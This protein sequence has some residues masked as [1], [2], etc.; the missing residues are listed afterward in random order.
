LAVASDHHIPDV[1]AFAAGVAAALPA[2]QAGAIVTFGVKPRYPATGFG[3]IRPGAVLAPGSAVRHVDAFIEKPP[4]AR[5]ESLI[6]QGCLWN[7]G[8]FMFRIDALLAEARLHA[9]EVVAAVEAASPVEEA[10]GQLR[11][12]PT[13][14]QTPKIAFDVAVME[15]TSRAA[16]LPIDYEWSDLGSWDAIWAASAHDGAGN[17]VVGSASLTDGRNCLIRA[18]GGA[19]VIGLGLDGVAVVAEGHNVLVTSLELAAQLKPCL[20]S[21][22]QQGTLLFGAAGSRPRLDAIA[23]THLDWLFAKALPVWWCFG[24]DHVAGGF[25]ERLRWD[26]SPTGHARRA[27]VQARQIYVFATAAQL[28]WRGPW[29]AAMEHGLAYLAARFL[30]PD[31]LYMASVAADGAAVDRQALL[32]DQA[33]V[34]LALASVAAAA[35]EKADEQHATA[36]ALASQVERAFAH[37]GGGWRA[38]ETGGDLLADP[39]M[40]LFEASLAW[41]SLDRH[42]PWASLGGTLARHGLERM[43]DRRGDRI[44]EAFDEAWR[45]APGAKGLTLEPGHQFEWAWLLHRWGEMAGDRAAQKTATALFETGRRGID[46]QSGLVADETGDDLV[47][48]RRTYRLWPQTE[49]LKAA[50][51]LETDPARRAQESAA[52]AD[53]LASYY[54]TEPPGLWRD[55][56]PAHGA[57]PWALASSLYH[58]VGAIRALNSAAALEA[59][60]D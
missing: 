45:P 39:I 43:I 46:P 24:A 54:T 40:H 10:P 11:L 48:S 4:A 53:G 14:A 28:G 47:I 13:F 8:N 16:V 30:R 52:A 23:A 44:A 26:L 35:P 27:R 12:P 31:G 22:A 20:D 58:I 51:L 19:S 25:A 21:L 2:A 17:V 38:S 59:V 57:E 5:A 55:S 36:V 50:L 49:W 18:E 42:G 7:S 60:A 41:M 29:R 37:P 56:P 32:Y 6:A 34:L 9:P 33:F 3:Y 1:A 15:K